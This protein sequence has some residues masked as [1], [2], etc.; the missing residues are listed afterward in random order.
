MYDSLSTYLTGLKRWPAPPTE[1]LADG[2]VKTTYSDGTVVT[3]DAG[4]TQ[5]I[6]EYPGGSKTIAKADGSYKMTD[7]SNGWES[8]YNA[9]TGLYY[10]SNGD[11]SAN[12]YD[13]RGNIMNLH[14]DHSMEWTYSNGDHETKRADFSR[15]YRKANGDWAE[16]DSTGKLVAANFPMTSTANCPAGGCPANTANGCAANTANTANGCPCCPPK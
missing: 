7:E 8:S 5:Q 1:T 4:E 14:P 2:S 10:T 12:A 6:T 13:N 9:T 15:T 11:G 16:Y 3:V